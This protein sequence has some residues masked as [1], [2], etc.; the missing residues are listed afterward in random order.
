MNPCGC[1]AGAHLHQQGFAAHLAG[2]EGQAPHAH[3]G[4]RG[5]EVLSGLGRL[6]GGEDAE[7]LAEDAQK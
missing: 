5:V 2:A 4:R 1:T 7:R 3:A 6:R